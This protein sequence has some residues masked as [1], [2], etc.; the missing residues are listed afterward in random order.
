MFMRA[1]LRLDQINEGFDRLAEGSVGRQLLATHSRGERGHPNS[2]WKE[3]FFL[4]P[5]RRAALNCASTASTSARTLSKFCRY[6]H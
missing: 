3:D 1:V 2:G 6:N 5:H 4:S